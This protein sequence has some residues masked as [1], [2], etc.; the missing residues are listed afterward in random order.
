M[1]FQPVLL[2]EIVESYCTVSNK[3]TA[4]RNDRPAVFTL[5]MLLTYPLIAARNSWF[6]LVFP[7][8]S[9]SS[10]IVSTGDNGLSTRRRM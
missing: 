4:K 2:A 9:S 6:V 8:L 3:K 1:I 7:S 10:S 5:K